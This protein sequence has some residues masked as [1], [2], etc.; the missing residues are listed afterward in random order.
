MIEYVT[1]TGFKAVRAGGAVLRE[2]Q[3]YTRGEIARQGH[4]AVDIL[5]QLRWVRTGSSSRPHV[6]KGTQTW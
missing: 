5:L 3:M 6:N 4:I 1:R 2:S